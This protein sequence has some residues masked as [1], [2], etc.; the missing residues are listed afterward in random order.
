LGGGEAAALSVPPDT[1]P[2]SR[3]YSNAIQ[4]FSIQTTLRI[5]SCVAAFTA[6]VI[7]VLSSSRYL[8]FLL[9]SPIRQKNRTL[10]GLGN[11]VG[12]GWI[13]KPLAPPHVHC[14][15]SSL[16]NFQCAAVLHLV[17]KQNHLYVTVGTTPNL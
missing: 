6:F 11:V 12:Q 1:R 15:G 13:A 3:D 8:L 7:R 17:G 16:S 9:S 4:K 5:V 2:P 14:W 10:S